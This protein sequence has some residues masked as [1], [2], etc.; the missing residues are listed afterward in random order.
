M[1]Y[2]GERGEGGRS[3]REVERERQTEGA[4]REKWRDG[5]QAEAVSGRQIE[6]RY[7]GWKR[8]EDLFAVT[9]H[10]KVSRNRYATGPF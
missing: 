5:S 7:S 1:G 8:K 6:R 4:G 10:Y 2:A 3:E 9:D